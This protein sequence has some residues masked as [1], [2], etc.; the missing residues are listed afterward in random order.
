MLDNLTW[1]EERIAVLCKMH[2]EGCSFSAIG[3]ALGISKNACIGKAGRLKLAARN[4]SKKRPREQD[5]SK[6]RPRERTTRPKAV[7]KPKLRIVRAGYGNGLRVA[8]SITTEMPI[9][10]CVDADSLNKPLI[11][12]GTNDCKYIAGDP[13]EAALYCGLPIFKRSYCAEHFG[14]CYVEPEKRWDTPGNA[15]MLQPQSFSADQLGSA[16]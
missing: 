5:A 16:A 14:R 15:R 1:T 3:D 11:D 6:K 12:L 7:S 4:D 9:F 10:T 2:D 8:S 13:R